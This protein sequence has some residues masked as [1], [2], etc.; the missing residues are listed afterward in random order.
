MTY[1]RNYEMDSVRELEIE[2]PLFVFK[3]SLPW[4]D[5]NPVTM[6]QVFV[7]RRLSSNSCNTILARTSPTYTL[8][9]KARSDEQFFSILNKLELLSY[10]SLNGQ[11]TL[12]RLIADAFTHEV[13]MKLA[14]SGFWV[15][16]TANE[17]FDGDCVT[18][19]L[20]RRRL[21]YECLPI[22]GLSK[23]ITTFSRCGP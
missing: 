18:E 6:K 8:L 5:S 14:I 17:F 10:S 20:I 4:Q 12:T 2:S 9:I 11:G 7:S 3:L 1:L 23:Q 13:W 22:N 19:I 15:L 16:A 21:P